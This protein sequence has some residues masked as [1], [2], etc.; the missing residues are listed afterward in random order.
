MNELPNLAQYIKVRTA[1]Y[2]LFFTSLVGLLFIEGEMKYWALAHLAL[3]AVLII[4]SG[5]AEMTKER[6]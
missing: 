2:A 6:R 3:S 4:V 1:A 5:I